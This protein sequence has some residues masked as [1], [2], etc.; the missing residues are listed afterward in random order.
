[1]P[2]LKGVGSR[3]KQLLEREKDRTVKEGPSKR[4]IGN[5]VKTQPRLDYH[6]K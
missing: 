1:M 4:V 5:I 2:R 3:I 6:T